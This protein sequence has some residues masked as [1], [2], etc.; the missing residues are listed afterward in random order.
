MDE[1]EGGKD[2]G[3]TLKARFTNGVFEPLEKVELLEGEEVTL[4][5]LEVPKPDQDAFKRAAGSW[6]GLIDAE[7]LIRNIYRDRQIMTRPEPKL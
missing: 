5:I 1:E 2:M 3:G 4:T 7:E 6:K